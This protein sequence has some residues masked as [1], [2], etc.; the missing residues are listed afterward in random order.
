MNIEETRRNE[1]AARDRVDL[2]QMFNKGLCRLKF[3]G[4][5]RH[6][7]ENGAD[8]YVLYRDDDA[9]NLLIRDG[10]LLEFGGWKTTENGTVYTVG[11]SESGKQIYLT[12]NEYGMLMLC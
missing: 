6:A 3:G 8:C 2:R 11:T 9:D 7:K 5:I 1:E 4:G 12:E 10:E